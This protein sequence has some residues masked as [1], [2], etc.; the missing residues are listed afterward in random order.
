MALMAIGAMGV[1]T[2]NSLHLSEWKRLPAQVVVGSSLVEFTISVKQSNIEA[3]Y[4]KAL[5]VSTP[6]N[7][8]YGQYLTPNAIAR[9]TAASSRDM[10]TVVTWLDEHGI[11]YARDKHILHV[12]T[13]AEAASKLLHT[14]FGMY[15]R[16]SDSRMVMRASDYELP[17]S[18]AL[19]VSAIFGLHGTPLPLPEPLTASSSAPAKVTPAVL[20]QTYHVDA[21]YVDRAGKGT[22]AVAEFQGQLMSKKDLT[23]FVSR[24]GP[25]PFSLFPRLALAVSEKN[26]PSFESRRATVQGRGADDAERRRPGRALRGSA[27]P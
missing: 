15:R 22:Q 12:R 14:E 20:A 11:D 17:A 16:S 27:V 7:P 19:A 21:P 6:G 26:T 8:L 23:D 25:N 24:Q 4:D 18:V 13:T 3:L 1:L 10:R 2:K 5:A 9:L